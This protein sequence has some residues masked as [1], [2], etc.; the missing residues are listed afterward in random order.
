MRIKAAR[1]TATSLVKITRGADG[2]YEMRQVH[3]AQP[4][5]SNDPDAGARLVER[6]RR[7]PESDV[8]GA[9]GSRERHALL[10]SAR[11]VEKAGPDDRYGD[12]V[13]DTNESHR[14][15]KEW[16]AQDASCARP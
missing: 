3:G 15:Y 9:A 7:P 2:H 1:A 4:F 11:P 10:A 5:A 16:M 8:P 14:L 6:G 12:I 13:V